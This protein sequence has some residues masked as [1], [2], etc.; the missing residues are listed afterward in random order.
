MVGFNHLDAQAAIRHCEM[1]W[2]SV[3]L[4]PGEQNAL[5][6]IPE[7]REAIAI[8]RREIDAGDVR[9]RLT[10]IESSFET[11]FS[12]NN[13]RGSD[14][15]QSFQ[16]DLYANINNLKISIRHWYASRAGSVL[17]L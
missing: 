8:L 10:Q 16:R 6:A 12:P 17:K 1:L 13:W 5:F 4:G 15:G 14:K 9:Q 2:D 3:S 11:W 7:A